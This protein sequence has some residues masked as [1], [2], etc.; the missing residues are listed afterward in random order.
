MSEPFESRVRSIIRLA[1]ELKDS[2]DGA[3]A[4]GQH[5]SWDSLGH[6]QVVS[7]IEQQFQVRFPAFSISKLTT[8]E[9]IVQ[10]LQE[11]GANP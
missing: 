6:M 10:E 1:L 5:P 3:L 8:V 7:A 9:A 2:E 4:M 11:L